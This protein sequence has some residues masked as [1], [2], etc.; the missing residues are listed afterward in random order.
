MQAKAKRTRE[1]IEVRHA[2]GCASIEG[3]RCNCDPSYR[4]EVYSKR[5]QRKV[6]KTFKTEQEARDWRR[7]HG[8]AL[9]RGTVLAARAITFRE[10]ST[11]FLDGARDGT[12]RNRS[13]DHFKPSTIRGY[14]EAVRI[15]LLPA[16]GAHKLPD[17]RRSDLQRLIGRWLSEGQDPSTIRNTI[18]AARVIY[19]HAVACE[20]VA[21][22][23]THELSLPAVRGKRERI[24]TPTEATQLLAALPDSDRALWATFLYAGLRRGEARALRWSDVDL[25]GRIIYVERSWDAK[26][27]EID[28]K[29][30]AGRRR[31]PI[32]QALA[33]HLA[34]HKLRTR[35]QTLVFGRTDD[36]PFNPRAIQNR[37]L[38]AWGWRHTDNPNST[39]PARIW[40]PTANALTPIT[41]HEG[42]HTY[43]S[44]MIAA[45][46]NAKTLS[47]YMGHANISITLDRYGHLFPGAE[48]Q[49]AAMLD[50][51]LAAAES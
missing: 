10:A 27:G 31:V 34:E 3:R 25:P 30:H 24:A 1:G 47:T 26:E 15:R 2:K 9:A 32:T 40:Q 20:L 6:R 4:A 23:P 37:A 39:G 14:E 28:P 48:H 50:A 46:V 22:N 5:D 36:T 41:P 38:R 51:Y 45:G 35:T 12:I 17:I 44:L 7:D 49:A 16:V 13:G 21:V 19:R 33:K 18:N 8:H 29:S 43:A 42:R 11:Q